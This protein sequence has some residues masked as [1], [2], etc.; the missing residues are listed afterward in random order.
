MSYRIYGDEPMLVR[1]FEATRV[2]W[3]DAESGQVSDLVYG[4]GERISGF[5]YLLGPGHWFGASKTWKPLY[6]QH[7]VY[8][9]VQGTLAIHDPESGEVAVAGP[10]EAVTWRGTRYH[11]G[12][13]VGADEVIVLDWFAPA[14]RPPD[15]SEVSYAA[16]KR[17]V[18]EICGGRYELLGAWPDRRADELQRLAGE[19]GPVTVGPANSLRLIHGTRFPLLVSI[20]SSSPDLTAGT[21]SLRGGSRS[22]PEHHPGDEVVFALSGRLNVHLPKSGDWFELNRLD[23]LY[24]PEGTAHEYWSYGAETTTAAFCV[25]PGYREDS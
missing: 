17:D 2:L 12:Y 24:L 16:S 10:G 7:R 25:A 22:E 1:E 4:R 11:Y 6:D 9:V 5:I 15:V 13:N 3:G 20:L 21:F 19:G 23:C 8:Y 18:G 14:E